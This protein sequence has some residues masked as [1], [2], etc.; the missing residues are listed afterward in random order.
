MEKVLRNFIAFVM[1][2]IMTPACGQSFAD[3]PEPVG[4]INDFE[5][6][7][8]DEQEKALDSIIAIGNKVADIRISVVTLDSAYTSK[9]SFDMYTLDLANY[10]SIGDHDKQNGILIAFSDELRHIRIHNG[11]S[12]EKRMTDETTRMIID[13]YFVPYFKDGKYYIG[14]VEGVQA[15]IEHL[16]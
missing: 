7:F 9:E 4:I 6:R 8:T 11:Y 3:M 13:K 10:W 14:M 1:L 16:R 12:I 15:I 5:D 2:L